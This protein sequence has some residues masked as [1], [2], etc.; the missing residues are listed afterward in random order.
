MTRAARSTAL[1]AITPVAWVTALTATGLL[2]GVLAGGALTARAMAGQPAGVYAAVARPTHLTFAFPMTAL[3]LVAVVATAALL[4]TRR[5]PVV[6]TAFV[7]LLLVAATTLLVNVP[8]NGQ[9]IGEWPA[10]GI[11][12]DWA[13]IR[14]EW[15]AW[16]LLRTGMGVVAFGCLVTAAL[17]PPGGRTAGGARPAA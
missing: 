17:L 15:N 11:P 14:D 8:L 16:H 5:R 10:R 3:T 1:T 13:R 2:A 6:A 9:M 4:A 12:P 7:L